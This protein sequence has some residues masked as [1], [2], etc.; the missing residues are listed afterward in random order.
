MKMYKKVIMGKSSIKVRNVIEGE[1]IEEKV[2]RIVSNKES[3]RDG[4]PL[5]YTERNEGV[6]A[7]YNPRTD[8]FEIAVDA[9]TKIEKSYKARRE[10]NAKM[11]VEKGGLDDGKPDSIQ[12]KTEIGNV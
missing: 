7:S 12:G 9:T 6:G 8:R 5:I 2:E 11:K 4:A 1:T 10:E 3:I